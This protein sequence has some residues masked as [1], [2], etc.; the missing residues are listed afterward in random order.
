[1]KSEEWDVEAAWNLIVW[2]LRQRQPKMMAGMGC[3]G[4]I[5]VKLDPGRYASAKASCAY[6]Q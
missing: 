4:F 5:I 6:V 1:M 2:E 3:G